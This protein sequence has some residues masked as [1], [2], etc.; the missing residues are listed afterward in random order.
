M[1]RIGEKAKLLFAV[2]APLILFVALFLGFAHSGLHV[3]RGERSDALN[4]LNGVVQ[5]LST[6]I[7]V[8]FAIVIFV[9]QSTLG[10]YVTRATRYVLTNW[11]NILM[12]LLYVS[13]ISSALWTMWNINYELWNVWM[14]VT[15][16]ASFVCLGALLPFLLITP[17]SLSP[18]PIMNQLKNEILEACDEKN[19]DLMTDR[20]NLLFDMIRKSIETGEVKYSL[21]G[22]NVVEEVV[23]LEEARENEWMF[24]NLIIDLLDNLAMRNL[25]TNP[26][27]ALRTFRVYNTI[28]DKIKHL[29]TIFVNLGNRIVQSVVGVCREALNTRFAH[30]LLLQ[31]SNMLIYFYKNYGLL[32]FSTIYNMSLD[33]ILLEIL[34]MSG[35]TG[36]LDAFPIGFPTNQAILELLRNGR[37]EEA[38]HLCEIVYNMSPQSGFMKMSIVGLAL[39]SKSEGFD[40]FATESLQIVGQIFGRFKINV[41]YAQDFGKGRTTS[42]VKPDGSVEIKTGNRKMEEACLWIK[43]EITKIS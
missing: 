22:F 8:V 43:E 40:D 30:A 12:L 38:V 37:N 24:F 27:L 20:T 19:F 5:G 34:K 25:R 32:D 28:A 26:N 9:V 7:A 31:A 35:E 11:I 2:F 21:E 18:T 14:D 1:M 6:I 29:S 42:S 15:M 17:K 23:K 13:T 39:D 3:F 41:V 36:L 10:K 4:I 16:T 33:P